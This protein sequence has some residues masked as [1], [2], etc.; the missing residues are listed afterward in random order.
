MDGLLLRN[1]LINQTDLGG[2]IEVTKRLSEAGVPLDII[3]YDKVS[4]L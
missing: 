3:Q 2:N 1:N 4:A